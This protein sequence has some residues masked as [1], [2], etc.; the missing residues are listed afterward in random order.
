MFICFV[1]WVYIGRVFVLVVFFEGWG[2]IR[3]L[4]IKFILLDCFKEGGDFDYLV[5]LKF[6]ERF[7]FDFG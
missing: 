1:F 4:C 2:I 6:L 3:F 5:E 7:V